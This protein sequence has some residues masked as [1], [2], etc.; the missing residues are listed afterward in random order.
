MF[1]TLSIIVLAGLIL[2]LSTATEPG[3]A[4]AEPAAPARRLSWPAVVYG[5]MFL[6]ALGAAGTALL[7]LVTGGWPMHGWLLYAHCG[8]APAF[9]L[10][11]AAV[12]LTVA[13]QASKGLLWLMLLLAI[14]VIL[15]AVCPMTPLISSGDQHTFLSVH[16]YSALSFV[17]LSILHA[18]RALLSR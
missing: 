6:A 10:G 8:F 4:V 16:R 11:A 1:A 17:V 15:S 14:A 7:A 9:A 18:G 2:V 3:T 5:F 13:Q 12:A